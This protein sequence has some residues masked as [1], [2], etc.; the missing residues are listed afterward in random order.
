MVFTEA[1]PRSSLYGWPTI[2]TECNLPWACRSRQP[3]RKCRAGAQRVSGGMSRNESSMRTAAAGFDKPVGQ[4]R[5]AEKAD[6]SPHQSL[7]YDHLPV[8]FSSHSHAS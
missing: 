1:P 4:V 7:L 2:Q 8:T 6:L 3:S 5:L